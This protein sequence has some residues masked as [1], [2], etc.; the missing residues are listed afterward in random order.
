MSKELCFIIEKKEL[1]MEQVLVDYMDVPI[2]FLCKDKSQYYIVLCVNMEELQY[3]V[4]KLPLVDVY[5]LLHGKLPMRDSI[6]KQ[7][8][9]WMI[10]SGEEI[11]MDIVIK[12]KISDIDYSLLPEENACFEVLTERIKKYVQNFDEEYLKEKY[13]FNCDETINIF[14]NIEIAIGKNLFT[15]LNGVFKMFECKMGGTVSSDV[16]SYNEVMMNIVDNS[17]KVE[18]KEIGSAFELGE[19]MVNCIATAA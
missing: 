5:E 3:I 11:C 19:S 18:Q 4:T 6:L 16:S 7:D 8:I 17:K 1:Y 2:F 9:Y 12:H 10:E 14:E 13:S 15:N